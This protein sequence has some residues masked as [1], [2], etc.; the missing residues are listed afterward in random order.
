VVSWLILLLTR[1][2]VGL[3]VEPEVEKEGLDYAEHGEV[4]YNIH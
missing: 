2:L 4:G 3:R 1:A